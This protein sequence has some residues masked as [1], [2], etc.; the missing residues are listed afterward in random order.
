MFF[1]I[2]RYYYS[3]LL[4]ILVCLIIT[5]VSVKAQ[6]DFQVGDLCFNVTSLETCSVASSELSGDVRIPATV[7]FGNRELKVTAIEDYAF[8][9]S[10]ITSLFIPGN[11][12]VI[13]KSAFAGS[14]QLKVIQIA[15]GV[16]KISSGA[17]YGCT[18]LEKLVL[19]PYSLEIIESEAFEDCR[20]PDNEVYISCSAVGFNAFKY[21]RGD[22]SRFMILSGSGPTTFYE[23]ALPIYGKYLEVHRNLKLNCTYSY[24]FEEVV[25]GDLV[26]EMPSHSFPGGS[27]RANGKQVQKLTIGKNIKS[28]P[29]IDSKD[30]ITISVRSS[31][32]PAAQGFPNNVYLDAVLYVP[33]GCVSK[34]QNANVWKNFW[35]IMEESD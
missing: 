33:K 24:G 6:S 2:M 28:V 30:L 10:H 19:P 25:F 9:N 3:K 23:N 27:L 20:V 22:N 14:Q 21:R 35:T 32:P 7:T 4:S 18:S 15:K 26:T 16:T 34:Y 13:G 8:R 29:K 11:V 12:K 1:M 5:F 31:N 17:F